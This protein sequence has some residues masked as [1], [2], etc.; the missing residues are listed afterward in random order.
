MNIFDQSPWVT[1]RMASKA[2]GRPERTIRRWMRD[3]TV[4]SM[5]LRKDGK[6]LVYWPDVE[7]ES[8]TRGR[9]LHD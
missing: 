1:P 7:R 8:T 9:R 2:F 6:R 4:R 3:G 5:C